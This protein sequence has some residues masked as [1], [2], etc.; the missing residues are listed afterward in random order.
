MLA[1]ES[2]FNIGINKKSKGDAWYMSQPI[3]KNTLGNFV[4]AM[5]EEAGIK[6]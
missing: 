3:G 5:C 2:P 1:E 4:K 6:G